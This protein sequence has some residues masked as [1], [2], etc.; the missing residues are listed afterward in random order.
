VTRA[1]R[2]LVTG[3]A[4]G[5][6]AAIVR[7]LAAR[8]DT[9]AIHCRERVADAEAVRDSLPGEGHAVV[10]ADLADQAAVPGLVDEVV[11][12]LGGIDVLVH[13]AGVYAEQQVTA[14]P[15]EDWMAAWQRVLSVNLLSGAALVHRVVD[16]LV[17]RPEGPDGARIV[18]VGSRGAYRGEPDA[19]AYGAS[20]AGLHHLAQSMAVALAPHGIAVAAVAPGFIGTEMAAT[21]LSGASGEAIR[22]QSPYHRV[23]EPAEVA[24]AVSWLTS[25]EASWTTGTVIDVN[26]ASHLR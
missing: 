8:G 10:A 26:G 20:K 24:A 18:M 17:H 11:R 12:R 7:A 5:I 6:G 25:P 15:Y 23:G 19:P 1:R 21:R 3:G 14:V 2:A 13:N 16:H 4:R 9:V 22:A